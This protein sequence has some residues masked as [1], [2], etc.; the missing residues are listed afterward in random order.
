MKRSI[1]ILCLLHATVFTQPTSPEHAAREWRITH[2]KAIIEEFMELLAIPNVASDRENIQRNAALIVRMMEKR[3]IAA[4]LI[5]SAGA[6]P[7]VFGELRTPGATRTLVF[8]AHYDGTPIDPVEWTTPPFEPVLRTR[9]LEENGTVLR[10]DAIGKALDPESRL[11]ARSAADDKAPIVA[12]MTALD[13]I[14]AAALPLRSNIKFV[15]D[16]EE[17]IGSPNLEKMLAANK[18]LFAGDLWLVC[19]APLYQTR[20]QSIIFGARGIATF[21]VTVYGPRVELHSGHYGNWV[22]NPAMSLARL[23]VSMKDPA[24]DKVLIEGFYAE[25]E[26]LSPRE[27]KA[28]ADAPAVDAAL[29]KDLWLGATD[30]RPSTLN[31][32]IARPSLNIRGMASARV[33]AAAT[34][35]IPA[36]ATAT[37]DVRLVKK[38]T[39]PRLLSA[40]RDHI[41]KQ[42]FHVVE[43]DPTAE[44]RRSHPRVAKVVLLRGAEA[45][46]TS[47]DLPVSQEVIRVVER[48]RGKTIALPTMGGQLPLD[49]MS[50]AAG[51]ISIIIPIGNHDNNQH[52]ANEN[53][54]IQNLWDGIE[55]MAALLAMDVPAAT[56]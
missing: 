4:R 15:F 12:L 28:I 5:S 2:E 6:N 16:G 36:S 44:I 25:V 24:T 11:Y 30:G 49:A 10:L 23:L 42:G 53:L 46:R 27:Q 19:D 8:Y 43:T 55:L 48:V 1:A 22:P 7:L 54:R 26:P 3:G 47:M 50:R 29:M 9:S 35:I 37:F 13:A 14:R 21:D 33:G 18:D 20:Q 32:L 45:A 52:S 51:A 56:H 40:M 17:E 39:V 31:E 38:M 41:R 34:N